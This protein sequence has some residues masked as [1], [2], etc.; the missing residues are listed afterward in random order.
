MFAIAGLTAT[1]GANAQEPP[2][3]LVWTPYVD[4]S[5]AAGRDRADAGSTALAAFAPSSVTATAPPAGRDDAD[6]HTSVRAAASDD[7]TADAEADATAGT[8]TPPSASASASALASS[9]PPSPANVA[10][11]ATRAAASPDTSATPRSTRYD[12]LVASVAREFDLDAKLL[13][14]MIRVESGYDANAVSPKGATGL[15]QVIP[16]TGARFGFRD[17]RDPHANLRAGATY[18]KW[19]LGEFDDDLTLALAAYNAGEG[20]VRKHRDQIPPYRET[21]AYVRQVLACYRGAC[22]PPGDARLDGGAPHAAA[23]TAFRAPTTSRA[24]SRLTA[25]ALLAKLGGLLLSTPEPRPR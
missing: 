25:G 7:E 20:A 5:A 2:A 24:S 9:N 23:Q 17:L 3:P 11:A 18:L 8:S 12:T 15:M 13:H 14:A 10:P 22:L 1:R 19:L 21:Q 4:E 16:A 6:A